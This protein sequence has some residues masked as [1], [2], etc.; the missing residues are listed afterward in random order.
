MPTPRCPQLV[1]SRVVTVVVANLQTFPDHYV[2]AAQYPCPAPE[3]NMERRISASK[4]H[5]LNEQ[6][7]DGGRS[8]CL[9]CR[10]SPSTIRNDNL[11][12][13]A[14]LE[15]TAR[16]THE[17]FAAGIQYCSCIKKNVPNLVRSTDSAC[18]HPSPEHP[19]SCINPLCGST[20]I[21]YPHRKSN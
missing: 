18:A 21:G 13:H 15:V 6:D 14:K 20:R 19:S 8:T 2:L 17:R 12:R 7:H 3:G 16:K 4:L 5:E 11:F 9:T 1:Q 10:E